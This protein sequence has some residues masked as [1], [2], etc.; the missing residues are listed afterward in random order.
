MKHKPA[1]CDFEYTQVQ[2]SRRTL[3]LNDEKEEMQKLKARFDGS[4]ITHEER[5]ASLKAEIKE[6][7]QTSER[8]KQEL[9]S[10]AL[11]DLRLMLLPTATALV[12]G[13]I[14]CTKGCCELN[15]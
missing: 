8:L 7:K 15:V 11:C 12:C 1:Y 13:D 6:L 14:C 10:T 5:V 2:L 9:T 3:E 4:E